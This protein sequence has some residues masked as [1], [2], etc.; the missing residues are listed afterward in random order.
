MR[1]RL[2]ELIRKARK[3]TKG[4]NCD[5]EREMR[6]A[7]FLLEN[8][9]IVP[10][11]KVGDKVYQYDTAGD[12]YELEIT[13]IIY[14]TKGIAFDERAIGKSIFLTKEVFEYLIYLINLLKPL[15]WWLIGC[16]C[17][18]HFLPLSQ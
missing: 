2:I 16:S 10:P 6:F 3:N 18:W 4:A 9:V 7:D 17:S 15:L 5:L 1:D 14:D 13:K 12:I 8:G 11:C